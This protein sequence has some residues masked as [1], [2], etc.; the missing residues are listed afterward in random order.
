[1]NHFRIAGIG[2]LFF[3]GL[4][5]F[6]GF[7]QDWKGE[8]ESSR[9]SLG[10]LTGMGVVDNSSGFAFIGTASAKVVPHG[11][12]PDLRDSVSIE[13]QMGPLL[14]NG[15]SSW[16]F[17]GHLRWDF[18]KDDQWTFYALGGLAGN[19]SSVAYSSSYTTSSYYYTHTEFYFRFGVGAFWKMAKNFYWRGELSHELVA[20]GVIFPI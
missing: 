9:F 14:I 3:L 15:Y 11:F 16:H 2:F 17:S 13:G 19:V 4:T 1:M 6:D 8:P 18:E 10:A 20:L 12:A 7:A 5:A